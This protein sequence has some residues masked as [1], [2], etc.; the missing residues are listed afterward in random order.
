VPLLLVILALAG[1]RTPQ[2]AVQRFV[3]PVSPA[4]ACAQLAPAYLKQ[5]QSVYGPCAAGVARNPKTSHITFSHVAIH[6]TRAT[7][8]VSYRASSATIHERYKLARSKGFW[9]ITASRQ[10]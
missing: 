7:L 8:Q 1:A 3:H 9:R 4:D 5:I 10:L 2:A 6:G